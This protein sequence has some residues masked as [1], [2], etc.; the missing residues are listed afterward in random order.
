M[1]NNIQDNEIIKMMR[2]IKPIGHAASQFLGLI[3][4][5]GVPFQGSPAIISIPAV[6]TLSFPSAEF[7]IYIVNVDK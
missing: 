6:R 3:E 5:L 7:S 2:K 1:N 4:P